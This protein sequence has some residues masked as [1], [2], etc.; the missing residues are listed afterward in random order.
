[1][2]D[3]RKAIDYEYVEEAQVQIFN[4]YKWGL[5]RIGVEFN[6]T[7]L[8]AIVYC[9]ANL[10]STL[11]AFCSWALWLKDKGEVVDNEVLTITLIN[12]LQS[13]GWKPYSY[14][15]QYLQKYDYLFK[16]PREVFWQKAGEILGIKQRNQT[17]ADITETGE[18]IFI[19]NVSVPDDR[20]LEKLKTYIA[21]KF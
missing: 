6:Q 17:I 8:E 13:S 21:D 7:L 11:A 4:S 1:M 20:K 19:K 3:L 2:I 10:G 5:I 16:S 18:I 12:A 15:L 9:P 14:Q